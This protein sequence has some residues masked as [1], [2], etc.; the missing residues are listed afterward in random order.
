[1]LNERLSELLKTICNEYIKTAHPIGSKTLTKKFKCSSAT[2]R[3]DMLL[4]ENMGY[5]EKQHISSGRIP[6]EKGYR[7]YVDN[8]MEPKKI[9]GEDMLKL[10]TIFSNNSLDLNDAIEKV[11]V[12]PI[13]ENKIVAIVV[14]DKGH[15]ENKQISLPSKVETKEVSKT[16]ELLN[17]MLKGT[18]IDEVSA[19][20][21]FEIKP[22]IGN[23]VKNYEVLYNAF[24][25]ALSS[26]Q[27]EKDVHWEGKTNILKQPEFSTVDDIKNI[28][29]KFENK[30]IVSKIEEAE[31]EVKVYIGTESLVDDNITVIKTKYKAGGKEGTLAIIGPK[32]MDYERVLNLLEYIKSEIEKKGE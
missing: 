4:L 24:Y 23:Y 28:I 19:K 9:S 25:E 5:L 16:S 11:E 32:R 26:F 21:E 18:P 10:Q 29:S 31:D 1:M 27:N 22:I 12:I 30:E 2:L 3:N 15:V 6:S 14:T 7:Y 20:L 17:K 13:N 8:L